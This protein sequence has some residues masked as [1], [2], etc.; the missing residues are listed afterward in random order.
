[1]NN[2]EICDHDN[3]IGV[4]ISGIYDGV[5]YLVCRDC[6]WAWH[7][8][9]EWQYDRSRAGYN[10]KRWEKIEAEIQKINNE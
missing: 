5:C 1:M 4:E 3:P 8:F 2:M 7:R 6:G 10:R 9:P